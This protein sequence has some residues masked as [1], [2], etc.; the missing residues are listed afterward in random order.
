MV[1]LKIVKIL[2]SILFFLNILVVVGILLT[3]YSYLVDPI[4]LPFFAPLG[5]LF[6]FF[7]VGNFVFLVLWLLIKPLKSLLPIAVFVVCYPPV[8][9]YIG[10]N[11]KSGVPENAIKVMTYNVLDFKGM[12]KELTKDDNQIVYFILNEDA[13]IVC[14]QECPVGNL[15]QDMYDRLYERYPYHHFTNQGKGLTSLSVY[16]KYEITRVDSI[17]CDTCSNISVAYTVVLPEGYAM[18]VNNHFESNKFKPD[19]KKDFRT[20]MLGELETDSARIESRYIYQQYKDV[21]LRRNAQVKAVEEF[22]ELNSDVPTIL[23]GDFNDTPISYNYH[24]I[25]RHLTDCFRSTGLGFG[26]T[27]CHNGMRVRIDNI[28]CS[29]QFEA[30]KCKVL[31][32]ITYSDHYPVVCWLNFKE[33]K[34]EE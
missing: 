28:M 18:V 22:L 34:E 33:E 19:R 32:D 1:R 6:P 10:L 2:R 21:A 14:L 27:Y 24:V 20:M 4:R 9:M 30:Y 16:S 15:S 25:A 11:I 3:G 23:C 31:S 5:L 8:S 17:P 13:D 12:N 29:S 7:L 26:W